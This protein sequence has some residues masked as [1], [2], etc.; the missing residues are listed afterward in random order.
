MKVIVG[1]LLVAFVALSD[2]NQWQ[3]YIDNQLMG[4]GIVKKAVIAGLDGTI[5]AKSDNWNPTP[6]ELQIVV[7]GIDDQSSLTMTGVYLSGI[8]YVYLSGRPM[9]VMRMK[10]GK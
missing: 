1:L 10:K 8:R 4:S 5:W 9:E 6:E 2:A 3:G 7:N